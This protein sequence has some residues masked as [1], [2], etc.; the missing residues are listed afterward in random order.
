MGKFHQHFL[1]P[2]LLAAGLCH[3]SL[4]VADEQDFATDV[5]VGV[6]K[7][8]NKR[9]DADVAAG[10]RLRNN[11]SELDRFSAEAGVGYTAIKKWLDVEAGYV[12]LADWNG[13]DDQY[14]TFRHRYS[15]GAKLY[16]KVTP[17]LT[18]GFRPKW[19]STFRQETMKT[20]KWNPKNYMRYRVEAEYKLPRVPLVP[21]V[22]AEV[23][24]QVNN[25]EGNVV[26]DVRYSIGLKYSLNRNNAF[27]LGFQ[28]DDE[29]N[30]KAPQDRFMLCVGYKYKF[31]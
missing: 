10:L 20:Y 25:P 30:V 23:F 22:S 26:D 2:L 19:Q 11:S 5:A 24:G 9:W 6:K 17:R 14:Y 29:R 31:K 27:D 4:S 15:V 28:V 12:F 3:S 18:L 1:L 7:D 21:R 8:I 13:E 16:H